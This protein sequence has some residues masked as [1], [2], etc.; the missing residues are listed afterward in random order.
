MTPPCCTNDKSGSSFTKLQCAQ[1]HVD[2]VSI[3]SS[4]FSSPLSTSSL[5]GD[6]DK[7]ELPPFLAPLFASSIL[8][9]RKKER[10]TRYVRIN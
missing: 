10:V 6:D 9:R 7:D 3:P 2:G 1:V 4:S 8:S 5:L